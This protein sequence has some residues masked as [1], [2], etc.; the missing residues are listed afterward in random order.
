SFDIRTVAAVRPTKARSLQ[1]S[2]VLAADSESLAHV[3]SNFAGK[4]VAVGTTAG[5]ETTD[6]NL[7]SPS[8]GRALRYGEPVKKGQLLLALRCKDVGEK[9]SEL[10]AAY[11]RLDLH[12]EDLQRIKELDRSGDLPAK[13]V[14]EAELAVRTDEI[15]VELA[16][17]TLFS[18]GFGQDDIKQL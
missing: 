14:R 11:A 7:D 17:Q 8:Q 5:G 9:K 6:P 10:V 18:W 1:L 15:S 2:G 16:E 4:V 13:L 3:Q 12:R